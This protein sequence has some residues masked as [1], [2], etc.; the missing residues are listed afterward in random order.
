MGGRQ[1]RLE[2]REERVALIDTEREM[3]GGGSGVMV[4]E[5]AGR[6]IGQRT[7]HLKLPQFDVATTAN[8]LLRQD[9]EGENTE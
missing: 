8:F 6:G 4:D 9:G 2:D 1:E 3:G 7:I 5:E